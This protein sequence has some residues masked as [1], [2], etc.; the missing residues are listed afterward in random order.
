MRTVIFFVFLAIGMFSAA[1]VLGQETIP[2]G[3]E[4]HYLCNAMIEYGHVMT[5]AEIAACNQNYELLKS[6]F[7]VVTPQ[8]Y[9]DMTTEDQAS[10]MLTAY[11][12]F[13]EWETENFDLTESLRVAMGEIARDLLDK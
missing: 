3:L 6:N 12:E 11:T 1:A 9:A 13:K 4:D 8:E 7:L 10:S 2:T 5:M